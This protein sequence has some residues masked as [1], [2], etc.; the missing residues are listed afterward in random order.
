MGSAS[1]AIP[2]GAVFVANAGSDSNGG[3]ASA[4]V[5]TLERALALVPNYGTIVMRGG[6]YNESVAIYKTV[7]IQ[8]YP[9]ESVWLDGSTGV[10][11]WVQDGARWRHDGWTIRFD[12]SP[13]YT[14]GAPDSTN[15]NWQFVNPVTAPMAAHPDQLW[16]DGAQLGQAQSLTSMTTN[17]FYLDEATSRLYVGSNPAGKQVTAS[18]K[19][20]AMNIRASGVVVRGIGIRRFAPS[21]WH[22]GAVTVEKP[23]VTFENVVVSEMATTGFSI[24]SSGAVLRKVTVERCGMLGIHGRYADNVRFDAVLS[25]Q[26]NSERFNIAPVSGGAKLGSSRGIVVTNSSFSENYGHGFW[27]DMSNYNT[28]I[29]GS[30]FN[31]NSGDGLFLE[32]SARAVVGDSL[33]LNNKMDGIK[34][35]NTSNVKIWNNTFLGNS[36]SIW[37]AQDSRR[38]T[39]QSDPAVDPR[40]PWPDPE[41]P[42]QLDDVT[43]S[44][45]VIGLPNGTA[46]CVLCVED[47][48]R[49][50]TA[51]SMRIKVNG[52][53]YD[54]TSS[55]SPS[56]LVVWSRG[57]NSPATFTTL[58]T[59]KS[60]TGQETRGREYVGSVVVSP[61]GV[62]APGVSDAAPQIALALPAD[63]ATLIGRPAGVAALGAWVDGSATDVSPPPPPVDTTTSTA[64]AKDS[65]TRTLTGGWGKADIGGLWT[66]PAGAS[67]FSTANGSGTMKLKA[68]DGFTA[69]LD[70]VASSRADSRVSFSFDTPTN[71]TGYYINFVGRH[72]P[73]VG[74]YRAK[75]RVDGTGAA[76]V[77]LV[78]NSGGTE[79]VLT[80][81]A[82]SGLTFAPG[83]RINMRVRAVGT[84]PTTLQMKVWKDAG[85]EPSEWALTATDSSPSFQ[86]AGSVGVLVY[87]GGPATGTTTTFYAA[88]LSTVSG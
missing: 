47:Y 62:L 44:N 2:S 36:R 65:F 63:V 84:Y 54:R 7:T 76:A 21:V 74:D 27:E 88:G 66:I 50:E 19:V 35:N 13:T 56:W 61:T 31:S 55:T 52:N 15:P 42:W 10:A 51:E 73:N 80:S 17:S 46:N 11:G 32:I 16:I 85:A 20:Q 37:L 38:N 86:T 6:A 28:V 12:H 58:S 18:N 9:G 25:R 71:A 26:N 22:V 45:N 23:N 69:R 72:V 5:R 83:N 48:S 82:M 64:I 14:R 39:K 75:V 68:G 87:S 59:F 8:N 40:I 29:R 60:T 4:P 43:L 34:V 3:T 81:R 53:V 41:M 57:A 77:W 30:N 33:F 1:Y 70:G 24:Q 79:S 49:L 67:Q 78:R